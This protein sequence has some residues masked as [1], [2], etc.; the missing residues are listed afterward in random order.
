MPATPTSTTRPAEPTGRAGA[1]GRRAH[2]QPAAIGPG[3]QDRPAVAGVRGQGDGHGPVRLRHRPPPALAAQ[4]R[5]ER[6]E[7]AGAR[8]RPRPGRRDQRGHRRCFGAAVGGGPRRTRQ[9]RRGGPAGRRPGR[10]DLHRPGLMGHRPGVIASDRAH[11]LDSPPRPAIGFGPW[12]TLHWRSNRSTAHLRGR[13]HRRAISDRSTTPPGRHP[14]GLDRPRPAHLPR[15]VPDPG[16]AEHLRQALR[17]TRVPGHADLQRRQATAR[18]TADPDDDLVKSLRGNEGWHTT[19]PTCRSRPRAPCSPPRSCRPSGAAT[20]WADM[21]AAY[22]ALDEATTGA[23]P[24]L[25]PTTRCTTARAEPVTCPARTPTAATACTGTTTRRS[26]SD[27]SS[28]STPKPGGRT[29]SS[30]ATPTTSS[31]WTP[32]SPRRFL[33]RL[34]EEACRASTRL[35]PR[36]DRRATR[37]SGT[38]ARLMHR[39]P[40]ST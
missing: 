34:N 35:L 25:R 10:P 7:L 29:S 11:A 30:G 37:W 32:R 39:E 12:G 16:R 6:T 17:R 5:G 24:D 2:L 8:H 28:R 36:V 3:G 26:R 15:P 19:A 13:R 40:R 20:G 27:P 1:A 33:D 38:T 18:S 22:E 21:R 4:R 9:L 23:D 31:A 14:Q